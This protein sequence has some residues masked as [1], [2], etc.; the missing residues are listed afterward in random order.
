MSE[1]TGSANKTSGQ[2][3]E[4]EVA[5]ITGDVKELQNNL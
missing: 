5:R 1:L 3:L 2:H 4:L